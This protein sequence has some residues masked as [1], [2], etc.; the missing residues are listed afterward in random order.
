MGPVQLYRMSTFVSINSTV[1]FEQIAQLLLDRCRRKIVLQQ[2]L[3]KY[4][5]R[6][7]SQPVRVCVYLHCFL[8]LLVVFIANRNTISGPFN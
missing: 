1:L 8:S 6:N 2:L 7:L 3:F 4:A 5:K